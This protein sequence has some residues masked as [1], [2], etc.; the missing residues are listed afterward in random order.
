[1]R[2]GKR[3][4]NGASDL[5][6]I[7]QQILAQRQSLLQQLETASRSAAQARADLRALWL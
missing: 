1:V 6:R 5:E 7:N 3:K 2:K 4:G